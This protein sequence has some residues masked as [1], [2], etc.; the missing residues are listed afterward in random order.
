MSHKIHT[1]DEHFVVDGSPTKLLL[2][3]FWRWQSSDLLNNTT[4][5]VF[6]E[7][8]VASALGISTEAPRIDWEPYD[9][10]F[11]CRWRIEVK[12]SAYLQSW[13]QERDSKLMFTT[14][15]TR[16][17]DSTSGFSGEVKR[18]SD[19]YIFCVFTP[20]VSQ[21]DIADPL[22]LDQWEFYPVLTSEL[23]AKIPT[24]KT[25][26]ISSVRNL[27]A[28]PYDYE[29][30]CDGVQWLLSGRTDAEALHRVEAHN[31]LVRRQKN[32]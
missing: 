22:N 5:G 31:A 20:K 30:L 24:N 27:C 3:D 4:R 25:A 8:I 13:H 21:A 26:A 6:A 29:S 10:L 15:P 17:W 11:Q 32:G 12:A 9:L 18:Q 28:A 16:A 19:M 14:R 2:N 1:G 7:F 23:E